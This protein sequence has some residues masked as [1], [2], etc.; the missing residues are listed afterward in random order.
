MG[1]GERFPPRG[2]AMAY[3]KDCELFSYAH[4]ILQIMCGNQHIKAVISVHIDTD[5]SEYPEVYEAWQA[6]GGEY[7]PLT[8]ARYQQS[9]KWGAGFAG[10]KNGDKTAK[11]AL[12]LSMAGSATPARLSRV[13]ESYPA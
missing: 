12:A 8:I 1:A 7:A 9:K 4:D 13:I 11:L 5:C 6:Q 2:V 10:R 3:T